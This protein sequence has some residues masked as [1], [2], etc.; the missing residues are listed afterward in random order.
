MK[1]E[2]VNARNGE[3]DQQPLQETMTA[4]KNTISEASTITIEYETGKKAMFNLKK[5][6][7]HT[8]P[9][10]IIGL[11]EGVYFNLG[12]KRVKILKIN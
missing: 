2:S 7:L 3:I 1:E 9:K 11:T 5:Q 12:G 10:S 8:K 6:K 4:E